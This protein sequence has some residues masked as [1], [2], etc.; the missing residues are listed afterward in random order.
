ME[1]PDA[2]GRRCCRRVGACLLVAVWRVCLVS[3]CGCHRSSMYSD[4]DM[5]WLHHMRSLI[6][7]RDCVALNWRG[8]LFCA[9]S[10]R[11]YTQAWNLAQALCSGQES[12]AGNPQPPSS[13]NSQ[14]ELSVRKGEMSQWMAVVV[15]RTVLCA[16][17]A[18]WC[19]QVKR[20]S[21]VVDFNERCRVVFECAENYFTFLRRRGHTSFV[22]HFL[23][24]PAYQSR[25][26]HHTTP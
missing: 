16:G 18:Y 3:V 23:S 21:D 25:M 13:A 20:A 5:P 12:L 22:G 19:F 1:S 4:R 9:G 24:T 2:H 11:Q 15:Q 14:S 26:A 6:G 17:K 8:S 10:V 7:K